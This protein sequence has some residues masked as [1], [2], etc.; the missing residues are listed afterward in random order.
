[1]PL[2]VRISAD[3]ERDLEKQYNWYGKHADADVAERY[4]LAFDASVEALISHPE[5]GTAKYYTAARLSGMR[6]YACRD[7]FE[8]HMIFYRADASELSIERVMH[9]ARDLPRRL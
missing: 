5:L 7:P 1:M 2:K 4:K 8:K 9:G 3:A 6:S